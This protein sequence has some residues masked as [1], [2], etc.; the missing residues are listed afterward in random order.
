[1]T[2]YKAKKT[3]VDGITFDSMK[4]SKRYVQLKELEKSGKITDLQLQVKYILFDKSKYGRK[5][6]YI[7][8]FVYL[9]DKNE[10]VIEDVKGFKT[11]VYRLK[12]RV[13]EEKYHKVINE[14]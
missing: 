10:E 8:D 1:M 6:S 2:K 14:I 7:A 12:K 3:I 11:P 9:N 13:F 5:L 4:E